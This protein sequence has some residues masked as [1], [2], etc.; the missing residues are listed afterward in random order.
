MP[1]RWSPSRRGPL[2][3]ASWG[4]DGGIRIVPIPVSGSAGEGVTWQAQDLYR[5]LS[6]FRPDIVQ[7]EAEP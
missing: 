2:L 7:I 1:A 4:N 6:D 5:L 3:S